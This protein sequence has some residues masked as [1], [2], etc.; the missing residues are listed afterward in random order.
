MQTFSRLGSG[1][2]GQ[3]RYEI[4]FYCTQFTLGQFSTDAKIRQKLAK[5]I[6]PLWLKK[7]ELSL[8]YF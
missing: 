3:R 4:V 1:E 5:K 8:H 2:D 7:S 6:P